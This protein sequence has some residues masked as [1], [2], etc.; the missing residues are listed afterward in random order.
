MLGDIDITWFRW[1]RLI[2]FDVPEDE[3]IRLEHPRDVFAPQKRLLE[4]AERHIGDHL[5]EAAVH[6][7]D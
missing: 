2:F 7:L 4:L 3:G 5:P 1:R 6:G